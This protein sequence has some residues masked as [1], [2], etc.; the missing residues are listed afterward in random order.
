MKPED[1]VFDPVKFY[2]TAVAASI[3]MGQALL[4][5]ALK[6]A[7]TNIAR[8]KDI[9]WNDAADA[10][11]KMTPPADMGEDSMRESF[12][13]AADL[14]LRAWTHAAD[15]LSASSGFSKAM[16]RAPGTAMTDWFDR[17]RPKSNPDR[18]ANDFWAERPS[19]EQDEPAKADKPS[20][21]DLPSRL[22]QPD[23]PA[24]DL[25]TIKGIGPKL[26]QKLNGLGIYH[27]RQIAAWTPKHVSWIDDQLAFKGRVLREDWIGQAQTLVAQ[28][29]A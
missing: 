16:Y 8:A 20:E 21:P 27:F 18:P 15:L 11:K 19:P 10:W 26:S 2:M 3:D 1:F 13:Y 6:Q 17:L 7:E 12:H 24:D 25:T 5:T 9:D 4:D 29:A 23:G 22:E 14:N 28:A